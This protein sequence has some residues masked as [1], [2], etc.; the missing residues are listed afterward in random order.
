MAASSCWAMLISAMST[1]GLRFGTQNTAEHLG[2]RSARCRALNN[3]AAECRPLWDECPQLGKDATLA[4]R[5]VGWVR[6]LR[7]YSTPKAPVLLTNTTALNAEYRYSAL[8]AVLCLYG[9]PN[10]VNEMTAW[11]PESPASTAANLSR[12]CA[13]LAWHT[14][15]DRR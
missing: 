11:K 9:L 13:Y 6:T 3:S 8:Q 7:G 12:G 2:E 1:A 4:A 14:E 15:R 10:T 5:A